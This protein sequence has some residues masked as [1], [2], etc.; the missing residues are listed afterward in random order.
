MSARNPLARRIAALPIVVLMLVG[1]AVWAA[2]DKPAGE[3]TSTTID[4]GVVVSDVEKSVTFYKALG[5]TEIEGFD[6]PSDFATDVGLTDEQPFHVHVL[7]LGEGDTATKLKLIQFE[8]S[9]G[10][11]IDNGYI[12]SSLGFRY[13]TIW[14]ADT[15]AAL[16]RVKAAGAQPVAKG[17][18]PLPAGF[19][20]GVFLTCVKDP[21]GNMVELVGPRK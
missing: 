19:P 21:D 14:V 10:S 17:P 15:S 18:V 12:H 1:A 5:F 6:V 11:Q 13:L 2:A 7:V 8:K 16:A 20:E 4:L 3:F 9:P